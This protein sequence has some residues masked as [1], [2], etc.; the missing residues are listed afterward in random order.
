[1]GSDDELSYITSYLWNVLSTYDNIRANLHVQIYLYE[2]KCQLIFTV[3]NK[4]KSTI[5][6]KSVDANETF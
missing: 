4:R 6:L 2:F 1:M 3:E 5:T